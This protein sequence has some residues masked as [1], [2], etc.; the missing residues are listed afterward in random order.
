MMIKVPRVVRVIA[1]DGFG[2]DGGVF[3]LWRGREG[4]G[5]EGGKGWGMR[6]GIEQAKQGWCER[7]GELAYLLASL[8]ARMNR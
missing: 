1:S 5:G 3:G 4:R 8:L 6:M 2:G 7:A